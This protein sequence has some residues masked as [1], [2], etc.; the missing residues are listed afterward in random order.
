MGLAL[1]S[2]IGAA[3]P[4]TES[5]GSLRTLIRLSLTWHQ[6]TPI[7]EA[8]ASSQCRQAQGLQKGPPT[9][10][11]A[12]CHCGRCH[13]LP[14]KK[15]LTTAFSPFQTPLQLESCDTVLAM[16]LQWGGPWGGCPSLNKQTWFQGL[17]PFPLIW[18]WNKDVSRGA[19]IIG[20]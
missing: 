16:G 4:P 19:A 12:N 7:L 14:T 13:G 5:Q 8:E 3:W 1:S 6:L 15:P 10:H 11:P 20:Y 9:P 18:V 2:L 17:W